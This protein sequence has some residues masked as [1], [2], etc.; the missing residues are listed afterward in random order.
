MQYPIT[1]VLGERG[2]GKTLF[3]TYLA[4]HYAKQGKKIVCNYHLFGIPYT[5]MKVKEIAELKLEIKDSIVFI[6]EGQE[7]AD[8]YSFLRKA[9]QKLTKFATQIRKL[10]IV[11]Y[12]STQVF[13]QIAKRLRDQTNFIIQMSETTQPGVSQASIF[14]YR[15]AYADDL[16]KKFLFD[17]R[18]YFK[19]YDTE[20]IIDE[21]DDDEELEN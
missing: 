8:S 3:M 6:D 15:Q 18:E 19:F 1:C 20:E 17:G 4:Y 9:T 14:N 12:Y 13:G 10:K 2:S 5:Y 7:G 21:S 16:I 11:M